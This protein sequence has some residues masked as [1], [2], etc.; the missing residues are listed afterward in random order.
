M[1]AC[2]PGAGTGGG[3]NEGGNTA[4]VYGVA[5]FP[6]GELFTAPANLTSESTVGVAYTDVKAQLVYRVRARSVPEGASVFQHDYDTTS[7]LGTGDQ[8]EP[9][10]GDY[11]TYDEPGTY[12]MSF[13]ALACLYRNGDPCIGERDI[14]AS[15][16]F[17]VI[18]GFSKGQVGGAAP[19]NR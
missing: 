15:Q 11:A 10:R 9:H 8:D 14:R 5:V 19:R 12:D 2:L 4:W 18:D 13:E 1:G 17:D 3:K 6:Y 16:L 7:W